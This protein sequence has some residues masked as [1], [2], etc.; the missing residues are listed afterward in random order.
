MVTCAFAKHVDAH[1]EEL[2]E[3]FVQHEGKKRLMVDTPDSFQMSY[4]GDPD[5]GAS[6]SEWEKF[7][8]PEFSKQIKTHVVGK[9]HS[10]LVDKFSTTTPVSAASHEIVLMSAM[11]NYFSYD[12]RTQVWHS[13]YY[14]KRNRTG[15][16]LSP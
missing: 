6:A 3:N 14:D 9:T 1:A 10:L 7:V 12:M 16:G 5:T 4:N 13:I 2:R 15:L 11:K 8:F